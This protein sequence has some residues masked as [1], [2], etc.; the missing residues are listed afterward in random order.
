MS[1]QQFTNGIPHNEHRPRR[2]A[3][4]ARSREQELERIKRLSVQAR[5]EAALTMGSRFAWLKPKLKGNG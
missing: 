3:C 4:A 1:E 2:S 5:I